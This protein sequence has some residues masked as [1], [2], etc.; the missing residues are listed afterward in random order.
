MDY[1]LDTHSEKKT[2]NGFINTYKSEITSSTKLFKIFFFLMTI[3]L[4][5]QTILFELLPKISAI[6]ASIFPCFISILFSL[7]VLDESFYNSHT[8]L[9][10]LNIW[11]SF[12]GIMRISYVFHPLI[13]EILRSLIPLN[14]FHLHSILFHTFFVFSIHF[15]L[16][17][18]IQLYIEKPLITYLMKILK[19]L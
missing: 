13:F 12:R 2:L 15:L 8:V 4:S 7:S 19:K 17:N 16:C 14:N 9:F 6:E 3:I 18:V 11:K 5:S 1:L 10:S